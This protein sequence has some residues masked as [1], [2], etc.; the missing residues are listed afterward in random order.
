[1][2]SRRGL[3]QTVL[4][5]VVSTILFRGKR[6]ELLTDGFAKDR[7]ID[8]YYAL[9]HIEETKALLNELGIQLYD[10]CIGAVFY[11]QVDRR[12]EVL[13]LVG[14]NTFAPSPIKT[15]LLS[16]DVYT[17]QVMRDFCKRFGIP[18]QLG[19]IDL[20]VRMVDQEVVKVE[21]SYLATITHK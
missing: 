16:Q 6:K 1:M 11:F 7:P 20:T 12:I 15:G 17:R 19:T 8:G 10:D 5:V 3:L 2:F 13:Q 21:Q 4:A 18:H 14:K 9:F